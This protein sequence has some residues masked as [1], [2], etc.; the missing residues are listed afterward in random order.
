MLNASTASH[1]VSYYSLKPAMQKCIHVQRICRIRFDTSICA[2]PYL[3]YSCSSFWPSQLVHHN[4]YINDCAL[5]MRYLY[6]EA[7]ANCA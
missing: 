4:A 3:R 6:T 2:I 5:Q 7:Y 1:D